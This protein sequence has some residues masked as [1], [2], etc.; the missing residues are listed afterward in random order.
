MKL[1]LSDSLA[2]KKK[3]II[4]FFHFL[5]RQQYES[6]LGRIQSELRDTK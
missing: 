2:K 6:E 5:P 3:T 1:K 4:I